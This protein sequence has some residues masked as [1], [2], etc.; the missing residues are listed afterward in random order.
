MAEGDSV[1]RMAR[2]V[3]AAFDGRT[4]VSAGA[5]NPRSPL[6]Q[7]AGR[8]AGGQKSAKELEPAY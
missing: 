8:L 6:R 5:P 1:F 3:E 4:I 2:L 7:T